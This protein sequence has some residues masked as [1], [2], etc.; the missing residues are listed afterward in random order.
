MKLA[1]VVP[2][3]VDASGTDRVIP[4]L[5][6]LIE[7]LARRH[8]VHVFALRQQPTP[9][10]W[11]LLGA[12]VHNIGSTGAWRRRL[13]ARFAAEHRAGPFHAVHAI[14]GGAGSYAALLGW[15]HRLPVLLHLAGGEL[16]AL[17]DIG[18]GMQCTPRGRLALRL[19]VRGARRVTVGTPSMQRLADRRGIATEL[20]PL[21]VALDRWP[22]RPPRA[23]DPHRPARLLH[24]GD[25]RPVKD[26]G[27][28]LAAAA[29][30]RDAGVPFR[31]DIAG[32]D[33]L[34]GAVEREARG[35]GL[36]GVTRF[37]GLLQRE[38]LRSLVDEA[39][40]LLVS[41]RHD[42]SPLVVLEA[43]VAGVP[44]VGTAVGYVVDWAPDAAV[45]VPVGD[46][47]ALARETAALLADEPR[48][49]AL[50]HAAHHR[51][52]LHDAD[53]TAACFERLY[54]EL[55]RAERAR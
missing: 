17:H 29:A 44:T 45:A 52:L 47:R 46:A 6:W 4:V 8:T 23:R 36:D 18:Y 28:L 16:V 53:H 37:H 26:Q 14:F 9:A 30:L 25:L 43:A 35:R 34:R 55:Q 31:L 3:G 5:L 11:P 27:T 40:L 48:R 7:R 10:D 50:A 21:G 13:F 19:A 20:V 38:A 51:A 33:T 39:D 54:A 42:A 2:G 1:L 32:Y 12:H 15:R 41:S 24:V 49:L 22:P